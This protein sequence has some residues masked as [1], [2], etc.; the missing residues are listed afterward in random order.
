LANSYARNLQ[1]A[2]QPA[3]ALTFLQSA[4]ESYAGN[5]QLLFTKALIQQSQG[6]D[7]AA[8]TSYEKLLESNPE[9]VVVLNNLA[10]IYHEDGDSRAIELARRAYEL[11]PDNGAIADTYGWIQLKSGN[12]S[13]S[14]P[15]LEKAHKLEPESEEIALHLAEAYRAAGKNA[16]AKRVLEKFGDQG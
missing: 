6:D 2:G 1:N 11:N 3:E 8:R 4:T 14:I 9:N 5:D 13:E 10:W 12:T 15:L 7:S 16:D